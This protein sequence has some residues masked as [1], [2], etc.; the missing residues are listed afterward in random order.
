MVAKHEEEGDDRDWLRWISQRASSN[1]LQ[2][3]AQQQKRTKGKKTTMEDCEACETRWRA[4]QLRA[5]RAHLFAA[6]SNAVVAAFS[7]LLR[8]DFDLK[9]CQRLSHHHR[10]S[11]RHCKKHRCHLQRASTIWLRY[12]DLSPLISSP[13]F[14]S[15]PSQATPLSLP[16]MI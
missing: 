6:A 10:S 7:E 4:T 12:E 9:I 15:A 5:D 8:F 14:I 3:V 13:S 11:P 1:I 2:R 16:S